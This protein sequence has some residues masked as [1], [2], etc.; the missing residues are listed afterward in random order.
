MKDTKK[1]LHHTYLAL[2]DTAHYE[3]MLQ[4]LAATYYQEG[5]TTRMLET[6]KEGFKRYPL[7][8][9]FY[10]HL[11][12]H[13]SKKQQWNE[14]LDL[15]NE[16][17]RK[18]SLNERFLL[19]KSSVLLNLGQYKASYQISQN[20]LARNDSLVEANLNAGLALFN[21]GVGI[22]KIAV[23]TASQRRDI[24]KY[25]R[26]ARPYIEM[27]RK[28]CPDRKDK[29]ALPLYTIYLNLNMGKQFDEIDKILKQ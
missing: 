12:D 15:T 1:T 17:L 24:L 11:I 29:W 3:M 21:Q 25:Y 22:D 19:A 9:F 26:Q 14:I 16:A 8:A 5:D 7:S 28:R 20:L 2:K 27:Y 13:Y 23:K 6:L 18:D 4:Y 10:P